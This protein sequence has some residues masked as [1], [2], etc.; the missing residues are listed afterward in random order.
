[1]GDAYNPIDGSHANTP[2]EIEDLVKGTQELILKKGELVNLMTDLTDYVALRELWGR[3]QHQFNGGLD[4]RF[5]C[6]LDHN[7]SARFVKMYQ[8][9]TASH[10][11]ATQKGVVGPRFCDASYVYDVR[12]KDL[13]SNNAITIF[14]FVKTKMA[15]MY[16]S[17]Y[18]LLEPA[19]WGS[20]QYADDDVTPYGLAFWIQKM[21]NSDYASHPEGGFYGMDPVLPKNATTETPT[22]VNRAG[23]SSST[24]ARWR[25]YCNQY[26]NISKDDL[27]KKMRRAFRSV[28]FK[29]PVKQITEPSLGG[30]G[31]GIYVN[32]DTIGTMEELLEAQNM[33]LGNDLASKDGKCVFKGHEVCYA[34]I[35][36]DDATDPVYMINWKTLALGVL[37]GWK[38]HLSEPMVVENQHNSRQVFLDGGLNM[39]CTNLRTQAV[40][41][42]A[43]AG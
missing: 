15:Q 3:H 37:A 42:K 1:M 24:Y 35:L 18:D 33:N 32:L 19:L 29:S 11:D 28:D 17:W 8:N 13:Q 43:I 26:T 7:H 25:N 16:Q 4:W 12:E 14:N 30:K 41:H 23:I 9:D 22:T 10:K 39:I 38:E 21:S 34:P 5:D 6:I 36:N 2:K 27:I 20:P 31:C 40:I